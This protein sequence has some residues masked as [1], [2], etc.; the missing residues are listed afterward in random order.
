[1]EESNTRADERCELCSRTRSLTALEVDGGPS[2]G[3]AARVLVCGVCRADIESGEAL[4]SNHWFCL[5]EAVWSETPAVQVLGYR[6]LH[7][8]DGQTW[9]VDLLDQIY[10]EDEILAWARRGLE[11]EEE[12]IAPV[13][14]N[15][16]VLSEG[17]AVTLIKD[18]VVKGANFTAKRGTLVKNIHVGDDP[19]HVEGRVN[20]TSIMLKTCF[21]KLAR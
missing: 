1:M 4:S 14:S 19:T 20:K 13:D 8:L 21:L 12:V 15:G 6:L 5:Q 10:L 9:A 3:V 17:D 7:R 2:E 11:T 18:L 16:A